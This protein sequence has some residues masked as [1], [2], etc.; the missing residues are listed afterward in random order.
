[1]PYS[2]R[3]RTQCAGVRCPTELT[4]TLGRMEIVART[5]L[6]Q[7]LKEF[8]LGLPVEMDDLEFSACAKRLGIP[9]WCVPAERFNNLPERGIGASFGE[10]YYLQREEHYA[11]LFG[12][13]A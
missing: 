8:P 5:V 2:S 4:V 12:R 9:I 11:R 3:R 10:G 1:M 13:A 6:L 7:I